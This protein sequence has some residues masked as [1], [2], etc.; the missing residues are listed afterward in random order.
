MEIIKKTK[1]QL[2]HEIKNKV[3][4]ALRKD[5]WFVMNIFQGLGAM[6]GISDLIVLKD[7]KTVYIEM[8]TPRKGSKQSDYQIDFEKHIKAHGGTYI[9]AKSV[10]DIA[11]LL[12]KRQQSFEQEELPF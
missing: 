10:E 1:K 6:R 8:K 12:D 9:V 4:G 7:G 2:E 3:R 5:G 11:F